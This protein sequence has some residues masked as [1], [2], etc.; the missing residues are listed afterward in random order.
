MLAAVNSDLSV[1]VALR[2]D[3][4][5]WAASPAPGVWRKPLDREGGESGRATSIVRFDPGA[6]FPSHVHPGG[7]EILVLEG[8][9]SD[10][11][12]D[13]GPGTYLLN[14]EGSSHAPFSRTGCL[15]FVKLCQYAGKDRPRL[16][17]QTHEMAWSAGPAPGIEIKE[18]YR[19]KGYPERMALMRFNP[20]A[21]QPLHEHPRGEEF[22]VLS[23]ELADEFGNYQRGT[24]VRQPA[25]TSHSLFSAT[26]AEIYLKADA[27]AP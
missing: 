7:E 3:E 17:L 2:A 4:I 15:L 8:I 25:G 26:G 11:T 10:E 5:E 6:S 1:R 12:G 20:G 13:Y 22:L 27:L 21:R 23:G 14:P 24:W 19:Q 16:A 18:L 9:F